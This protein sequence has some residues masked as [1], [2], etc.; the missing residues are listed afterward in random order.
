MGKKNSIKIIKLFFKELMMNV[1]VSTY[2][3]LNHIWWTLKLTYGI[4]FL[5]AGADKFFNIVTHWAKYVSPAVLQLIPIKLQLLLQLVGGLEIIIGIL[6]L[7][8]LTRIGAAMATIWLLI[9]CANLIAMGH[10]SLSPL[11]IVSPYLDIVVRDVVM[12]VGAFAL[13]A[14][15]TVKNEII[16]EFK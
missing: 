7:S 6:I 2:Q 10:Y 1:S 9:I 11:S 3:K 16:N 14:L 4:V 13:E 5:V 8:N 12:A 15:T